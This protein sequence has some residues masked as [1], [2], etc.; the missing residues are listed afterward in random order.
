MW[1][2]DS[3]VSGPGSHRCIVSFQGQPASLD[4]QVSKVPEAEREVLG[5]KVSRV[6]LA[7]PAKEALQGY[8]GNR[9]SLGP[10]GVQVSAS[11][12]QALGRVWDLTPLRKEQARLLL[13]YPPA[14]LRLLGQRHRTL[15]H[16]MTSS[17][18]F[19][20]LCVISPCPP[21]LMG[22]RHGLDGCC[23]PRSGEQYLRGAPS[24]GNCCFRATCRTARSLC[25]MLGEELYQLPRL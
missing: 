19:L 24:L 4:P 1:Q 20:V 23:I 8:Q 12:H 9:G 3:S 13:S 11:T 16:R 14:G 22:H 6:H 25:F 18:S 2:A 15:L 17:M 10:R 7:I 5:F 21:H